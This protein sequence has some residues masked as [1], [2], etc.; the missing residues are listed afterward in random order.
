MLPYVLFFL[1]GL[2]FGYAARGGWKLM[3]LVFPVVLAA[4]AFLR[5]GVSVGSFFKLVA[6]VVV[7]LI[8]IVVGTAL[9]QRAARGQAA[10]AS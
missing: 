6:A 5:D 9:D 2:G 3:P 4:G 10:R 8:G 7:M 1:A